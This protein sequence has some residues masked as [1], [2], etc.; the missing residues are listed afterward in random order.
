MES[1]A[2]P[3]TKA[4]STADLETDLRWKRWFVRSLGL[5]GKGSRAREKHLDEG[6]DCIDERVY[7]NSENC[8]FCCM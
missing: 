1:E 3:E 4:P 6:V 7:Q 5:P 2:Q 8:A